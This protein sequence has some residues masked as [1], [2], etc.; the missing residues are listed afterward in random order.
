MKGG[1]K[2]RDLERSHFGK[3]EGDL[4]GQMDIR[5]GQ[6]SRASRSFKSES[7][8]TVITRSFKSFRPEWGEKHRSKQVRTFP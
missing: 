8:M 3:G 6:K 7:P 4:Q 2:E 5:H 1:T